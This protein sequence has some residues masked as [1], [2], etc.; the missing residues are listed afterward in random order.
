ME[1]QQMSDSN[2][3]ATE[4]LHHLLNKTL[5]I[6]TT[7]S[8]IFIGTMK[9]TD[10]ELNI[11]LALTHEYRQPSPQAISDAAYTHQLQGSTENLKVDMVKR[12]VGLVVV[13]GKHIQ[14]IKV[15]E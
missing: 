14:K 7:D 8:R 15:E 3:E 1:T 13:P 4:Y 6:H 2:A 11:I 9:C 12:F 5:R 10:R